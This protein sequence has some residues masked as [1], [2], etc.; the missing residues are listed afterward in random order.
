MF[1]TI[2]QKL[3]IPL[4]FVMSL[5]ATP[6]TKVKTIATE[7]KRVSAYETQLNLAPA[8]FAMGDLSK[9]LVRFSGSVSALGTDSA[10]LLV[11]SDKGSLNLLHPSGWAEDL[12]GMLALAPTESARVQTVAW[13]TAD[14]YWLVGGAVIDKNGTT[15]PLL[16]KLMPNGQQTI[17]LRLEAQKYKAGEI[18]DIACKSN[19]CVV[20][21]MG[22]K[23]MTF[24]GTTL[25]DISSRFGFVPD[26][27]PRIA[28]NDVL[29]M[30]AG[31]TQDV[32]DDRNAVAIYSFDGKT[33]RLVSSD[34]DRFSMHALPAIALA[35]NTSGSQWLAVANDGSLHAWL[36]DGTE[37]A[38]LKGFPKDIYLMPTIAGADSHW[39]LGGGTLTKNIMTIDKSGTTNA[40]TVP[41]AN[42]SVVLVTKFGTFIGG[43]T[44]SAT[45]L[46]RIK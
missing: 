37:F 28:S 30:I 40:G 6:A 39:I 15:K 18:A 32:I 38:P 20:T 27:A 16:V 41:D 3:A 33:V 24:D 42:V 1:S 8:Q 43:A 44:G 9:T 31:A 2:A 46:T 23:I 22:G 45:M 25:S 19:M 14:S 34:S 4:S 17:N 26:L 29:W 7:S 36:L 10:T 21:A 12:S 13:N 11:G 5:T 35:S